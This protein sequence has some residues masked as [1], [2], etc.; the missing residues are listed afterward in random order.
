MTDVKSFGRDVN[1]DGRQELSGGW[2]LSVMAFLDGV[3]THIIERKM[4]I[5]NSTILFH[6]FYLIALLESNSTKKLFFRDEYIIRDC[7]I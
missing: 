3:L 1:K 6:S 4:P 2:S 7:K 5:I